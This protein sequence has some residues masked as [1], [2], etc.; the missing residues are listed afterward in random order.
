[1]PE[2]PL[3]R[4]T[5]RPEY[6]GERKMSELG[7]GSVL[8]VLASKPGHLMSFPR[9]QAKMEAENRPH[10]TVLCLYSCAV[11]LLHEHTHNNPLC[12]KEQLRH[13]ILKE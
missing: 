1:M 7:A 12:K 9:T 11:A 10:K 6:G 3:V 8:T 4:H 5:E 13:V 2:V